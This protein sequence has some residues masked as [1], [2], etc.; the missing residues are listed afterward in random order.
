MKNGNLKKKTHRNI[1]GL[2]AKSSDKPKDGIELNIN[3]GQI[4]DGS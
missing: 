4:I 2:E 3:Q 1:P